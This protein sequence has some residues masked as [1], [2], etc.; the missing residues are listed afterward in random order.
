MSSLP[1]V[2]GDGSGNVEDPRSVE[3]IRAVLAEVLTAPE[4]EIEAKAGRAR[5]HAAQF[6]WERTAELVVQA[7]ERI[8]R[9]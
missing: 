9:S 6:S 3:S 5:A 7:L 8:A 2:G 1:E 4:A